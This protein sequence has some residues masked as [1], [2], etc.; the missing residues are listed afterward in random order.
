MRKVNG[1][2]WTSVAAAVVFA[3]AASLAALSVSPLERQVFA[4]DAPAIVTVLLFA[5]LAEASEFMHHLV[6]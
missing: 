2:A 1:W 3:L 4:A 5:A 6:H